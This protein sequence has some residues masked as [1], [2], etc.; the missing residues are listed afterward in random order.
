[1]LF[2]IS[3]CAY[4]VEETI[5]DAIKEDDDGVDTIRALVEKDPAVLESIYDWVEPGQPG[6][7]IYRSGQ[8]P[9]LYAVL[10]GKTHAVKTLLDL[11]ANVFATEEDGYNVLHV[12]GVQGRAEILELLLEHFSKKSIDMNVTT[13]QHADGYYPLHVSFLWN[14]SFHSSW[15]NACID[16]FWIPMILTDN[17]LS[18]TIFLY[19]PQ[20][21]ESMLGPR[22]STCRDRSGHV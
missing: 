18:P 11:G 5:F 16:Y 2:A 17:Y 20:N 21:A 4:A 22:V 10:H 15:C 7:T 3:L 8:T 14:R 12:A 1:M 13:D 19:L 9:L 6:I